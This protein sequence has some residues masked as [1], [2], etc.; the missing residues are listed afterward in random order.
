MNLR[1]RALLLHF[2]NHGNCPVY[3]L[4]FGLMCILFPSRNADRGLT[5]AV[6]AGDGA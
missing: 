5:L 1:A 2:A 3:V 4:C 6:A